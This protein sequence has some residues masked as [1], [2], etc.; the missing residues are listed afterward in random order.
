MKSQA[1]VRQKEEHESDGKEKRG[2]L[3]NNNVTTDCELIER[4]PLTGRIIRIER[5]E[6]LLK[7]K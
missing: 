5:H 2:K 6:I 1:R 3:D 7:R 4:D